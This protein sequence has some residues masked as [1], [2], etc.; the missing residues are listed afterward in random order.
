MK[1]T[2]RTDQWIES[3]F[4]YGLCL[5]LQL[6][7]DSKNRWARIAGLLAFIPW[8]IPAGFVLMVPILCA[9]AL[10]I[11]AMTWDGEL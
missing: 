7:S 3:L 2:K 1:F 6:T 9:M 10:N 4:L 8:V 5:P 11:F